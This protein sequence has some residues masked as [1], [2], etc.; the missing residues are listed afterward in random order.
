MA[1]AT[2]NGVDLY[3]AAN[4]F[5][6]DEPVRDDDVSR[7]YDLS[8]LVTTSGTEKRRWRGETRPLTLAEAAAIRAEMGLADLSGDAV[9]GAT[10]PVYARMTAGP[11][12]KEQDG[13]HRRVY[14]IALEE[15]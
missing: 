4:R 8:L 2:L 7:A 13:V 15:V 14:S 3:L 5:D 9:G 1:F 10:V 11:Y 12:R 6:E